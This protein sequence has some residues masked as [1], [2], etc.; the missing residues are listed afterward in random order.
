MNINDFNFFELLGLKD[1]SPK[2]KEKMTQEISDIVWE[3]FFLEE[4]E[5]R[6]SAEDIQT[7]NGM[8]EE[9]KSVEEILDFISKKVPDFKDSFAHFAVSVKVDIMKNQF[10][11]MSSDLNTALL[12]ITDSNKKYS[13]RHKLDRYIRAKELL[14]KADWD[15]LH[16]L[17][18]KGWIE[19]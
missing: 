9:G 8:V 16:K 10:M 19:I 11:Q 17:M 1:I 5:K 7:V 3:R 12:S 13:I 18:V 6:L 4:I 2:D 15:N 14:D